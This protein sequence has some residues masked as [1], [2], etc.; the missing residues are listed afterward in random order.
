MSAVASLER[1][2]VVTAP[3]ANVARRSRRPLPRAMPAATAP[4]ASKTPADSASPEIAIRPNR[5]RNRFQSP[6][7]AVAAPRGLTAPTASMGSPPAAAH[8]A[9]A[10]PRG[11]VM[12]AA[13]ARTKMAPAKGACTAVTE[14]GY[15]R[16]SPQRLRGRRCLFAA[17]SGVAFRKLGPDPHMKP[18]VLGR[19][20][21]RLW[22][23]IVWRIQDDQR[24]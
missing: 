10:T 4:V 6:T 11:G 24:S 13:S 8:Q 23:V 2:A 18:A 1:T 7:T 20:A 21:Y 5:K 3:A 19:S 22:G 17:H 9:S 15:G 14:P 12:T 16:A